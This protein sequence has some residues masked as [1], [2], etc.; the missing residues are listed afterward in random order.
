[1]R[2]HTL[3][4]FCLL[5]VVT[6][7]C[8]TGGT[9]GISTENFGS[10]NS[11]ALLFDLSEGE[12][13]ST[14]RIR[15]PWQGG[16][17]IINS[18]VLA[19]DTSEF[20]SSTGQVKIKVPVEKVVCLSTTHIA[21]ID[22]L[23]ESETVC[24][25]SGTGYV[26]NQSVKE[27]IE[28]GEVADVGYENFLNSELIVS[29]KPG[30]VL[31]YGIGSES[32]G[33]VSK[34]REAGIPVMFISDYMEQHPLARAE[35]IRV[36]GALYDKT[37][38][39]AEIFNSIVKAY[40]DTEAIIKERSSTRPVVMLGLP[41]RDTWYISPGDSYI[42][43]LI[44]DAGGKYLWENSRSDISM[45]MGL[46]SV[47]TEAMKCD[48]WINTGSARTIDEILSVDS[49]FS[50]LPPVRNGRLYNNTAR[51]NDSGGNDYWESGVL[52][53]DILLNDLAWIFHPELFPGYKPVYYE[54][55]R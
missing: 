48:F 37:D 46:E 4:I 18:Y 24:G 50:E 52:H 21:M 47:F 42:S 11:Y 44:S 34:I 7:M 3:I 22:A 35:W 19:E 6:E 15:S 36:I 30:L 55:L 38:T 45:P 25:I 27:G 26:Y 2:V 28:K 16:G 9:K 20:D 14:L 43:R 17:E 40:N 32:E 29:M 10:G 49:R 53:P 8:S 41:Y 39:A 51:T 31:A 33:Y 5:P 1:M 54:K 13:R 12:G 23:G